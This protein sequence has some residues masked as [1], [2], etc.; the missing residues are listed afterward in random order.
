MKRKKTIA[1]IEAV[2][3]IL[4]NII[5]F[6]F[7][8]WIGIISSSVA[9]IADAWH[10]LSDSFSSIILLFGIKIS[11]KPADRE[12]PFGHGRAEIIA[13]VIIGIILT[14]VGCNFLIAS[15]RKFY[16]HQAASFGKPAIIITAISV[17]VKEIM[18]Q[19]AIWGGKKTGSKLLI[20]DGWHHR[21]DSF[22]SLVILFG[23][24]LGKFYWWADSFLGLIMSLL[25]FHAA[26]DIL[27]GSVSTLIGKKPDKELQDTIVELVKSKINIPVHLHHLHLHNYGDHKEIT[28]H[29]ELPPKMSLEEAHKIADEMEIYIR[30]ELKIES[31]IH[32]EPIR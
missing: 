29:I 24:F 7:K 8:F 3:S 31:T 23:I 26:F 20:A 5:L 2:S 19:F 22:S 6:G 13:T 21:T 30:S 27:K 25:I 11:N 17:V 9:I 32:I 15:I 16:S 18:A 4:L 14:F 1:Y 12:H 10:T 28:F